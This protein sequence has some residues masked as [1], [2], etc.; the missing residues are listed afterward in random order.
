[1]STPTRIRGRISPLPTKQDSTTVAEGTPPVEM[2]GV[3]KRN[4]GEPHKVRGP[5][6]RQRMR[7]RKAAKAAGM[8]LKA[9]L[10]SKAGK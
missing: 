1:M 8:P 5:Q 6:A 9:Y 2:Y 4:H 10:R 3:A 7:D